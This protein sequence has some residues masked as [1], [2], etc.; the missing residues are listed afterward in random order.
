MK[1]DKAAELALSKPTKIV[2][3]SAG[4][5]RVQR[6]SMDVRLMRHDIVAVSNI[7][8]SDRGP[9]TLTG[10][11]TIMLATGAGVVVPAEVPEIMDAHLSQPIP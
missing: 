2:E 6:A 7:V 4:W 3:V 11:C 10:F 1:P 8:M 5:L 9:G